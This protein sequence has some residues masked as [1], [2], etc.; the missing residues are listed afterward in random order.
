MVWSTP[1]TWASGELVT[2]G[3]MNTYISDDLRET[4]VAKV[5]AAGDL[6]YGSAANAFTRLAIGAANKR[7]GVTG[8][9]PVWGDACDVLGP[10]ILSTNTTITGTASNLPGTTVTLTAGKWLVFG[11]FALNVGSNDG[12][13]T[14]N[15]ILNAP[16][17]TV[18]G[19]LTSFIPGTGAVS[20]QWCVTVLWL[21]TTTG[22]TASLQMQKFGGTG[23]SSANT[24]T[25]L[26]AVRIGG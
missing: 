6:V 13:A 19:G 7:L 2:A 12:G 24:L 18:A 16:G 26:V 25:Q 11:T 4:G 9:V 8:G 20:C 23:T 15:G 5:A 17:S 22:G 10:A 14:F 1:R 21:V 3:N